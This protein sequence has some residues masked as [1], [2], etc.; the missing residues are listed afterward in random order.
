MEWFKCAH[1]YKRSTVLSKD[2]GAQLQKRT[3]L[4][5]RRYATN[6]V[7]LVSCLGDISSWARELHSLAEGGGGSR[8]FALGV[9]G[10]GFDP[11][12]L[13]NSIFL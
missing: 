9:K 13:H 1:R 11:R 8:A 5:P 12:N 2:F 4:L 10:P 6:P 7:L 3:F